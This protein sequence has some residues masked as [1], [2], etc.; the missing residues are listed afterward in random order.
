MAK[1]P[2]CSYQAKVNICDVCDT[3]IFEDMKKTDKLAKKALKNINGK[4]LPKLKLE[5]QE[6]FNKFIRLRDQKNGVF[7]CIS[8]GQF[9]VVNQMNAGHYHSQGHNEAVRYD[10]TNVNGQCVRCN[11]MLH[12]NA[13]GYQAGLIKK[14][15]KQIIDIL[16]IKRHNKSKMGKFE[17]NLLIKE[18][19]Q[20]VK[21]LERKQRGFHEPESL[22]DII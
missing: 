3:T 18:Y 4:S 6:V 14:Y 15:G 13:L 10:E 11:L 21:D 2:N 8:C 7:K 12:S 5:L 16:E 20:K 19:S 1:C 17:L 9:K 22:A